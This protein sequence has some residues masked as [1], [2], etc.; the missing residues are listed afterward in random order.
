MMADERN[1]AAKLTAAE[2]LYRHH[3]F[4]LSRYR[5]GGDGAEGLG[6]DVAGYLCLQCCNT[7]QAVV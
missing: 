4:E 6:G 3:Y 7:Q 2:T 5:F 1:V